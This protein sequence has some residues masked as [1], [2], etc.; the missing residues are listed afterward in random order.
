MYDADLYVLQAEDRVH[1][2]DQH[3]DVV[4]VHYCIAE[5]S[6]D[7]FIFAS[8]NSKQK[9]T[10]AIQDGRAK[11][12]DCYRKVS[13][14]RMQDG[15]SFAA[16]AP[17]TPPLRRR[18][19]DPQS[20]PKRSRISEVYVGGPRWTCGTCDEP[21]RIERTHCNNCEMI[22]WWTSCECTFGI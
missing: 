5:G 21:N 8:L 14:P 6:I 9:N 17:G 3:E 22:V 15:S 19:A 16:S 20:S 10:S 11:H 12:M 2:I 7:D 4:D 18:S 1:R 13:V